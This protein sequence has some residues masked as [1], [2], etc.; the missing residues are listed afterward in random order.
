MYTSHLT[1]GSGIHTSTQCPSPSQP[2][3]ILAALPHT[4]YL[5]WFTVDHADFSS[6]GKWEAGCCTL[7]HLYIVI[8]T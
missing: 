3:P 6:N 5:A 2:H 4:I 8:S 7:S 1:K